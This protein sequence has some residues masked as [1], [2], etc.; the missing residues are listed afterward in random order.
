VATAMPAKRA[1][2]A[3]DVAGAKAVDAYLAKIAQ[4][5]RA[6]LEE[7]RSIVRATVPAEAI[8]IFSYG[9]PGFRYKGALLWY[10]AFKHHC[11][12]FPGSPPLL[13]S[14][15]GELTDYK[16]S[17]GG[18]QIPFDKPLPAALLKKIVF[19]RIAE[20]EARHRGRSVAG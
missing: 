1:V 19:A 14:L 2:P 11:G 3:D 5:A 6:R 18:I 17:K 16:T 9:M 13:K 7:I 4:P 20:N 8:E 15:A 12:F 10:G